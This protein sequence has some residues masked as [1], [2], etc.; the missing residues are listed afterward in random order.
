MASEVLCAVAALGRATQRA[1]HDE[2]HSA[3][4]D[5][6]TAKIAACI[7]R[8]V[9]KAPPLRPEQIERLSVLLRS[10]Q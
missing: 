6:A 10:G 2:I 9:A 7:E 5:L 1:D 4:S 3:R 8:E